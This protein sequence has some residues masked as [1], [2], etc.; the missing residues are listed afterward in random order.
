MKFASF[1]AISSQLA[2]SLMVVGILLASL[3]VC[4]QLVLNAI[5]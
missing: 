5:G 3:H 4:L 2:L 1:A